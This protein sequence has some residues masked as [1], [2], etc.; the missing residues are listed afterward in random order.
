MSIDLSS[1]TKAIDAL[2]R[3][4]KRAT[5]APSDEELRDGCIQRFEFTYELAIKMLTRYLE[6]SSSSSADIDK[7]EFKDMMR[8]AAEKGLIASPQ[9][10][11][12]FRHARNLTS[13]TYDQ[14]TAA[15]V[16]S[17]IAAFLKEVEALYA[18]LKSRVDQL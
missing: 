14:S 7:L 12:T 10:W 13:H 8:V 6:A 16:F 4:L 2:K 18:E 15:E 3:G 5:A 1:F 9:V 11:F 17:G